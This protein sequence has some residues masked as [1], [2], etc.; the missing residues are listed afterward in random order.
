MWRQ[1]KGNVTVAQLLGKCDERVK[2]VQVYLHG[3]M[4]YL[5]YPEPTIEDCGNAQVLS[6]DY[7]RS[8]LFVEIRRE[9]ETCG[10]WL[11]AL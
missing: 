8:T 2:Y 4:R 9:E 7:S 3:E 6:F 1:M 11:M 5:N 10:K